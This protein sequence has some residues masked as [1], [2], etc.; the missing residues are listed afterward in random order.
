MLTHNLC[1]SLLVKPF[2]PC[3]VH[4]SIHSAVAESCPR[5]PYQH[6][7]P[8]MHCSASD[9]LPCRALGLRRSLGPVAG[10]RQ[11]CPSAVDCSPTVEGYSDHNPPARWR[12]GMPPRTCHQELVATAAGS[13]VDLVVRTVIVAVFASASGS[14]G[15]AFVPRLLDQGF[16]VVSAE[17]R[18]GREILCHLVVSFN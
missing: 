15:S 11:C 12:N 4:C 5:T 1:Q 3:P 8:Q 7:S 10:I 16:V 18:K 17:P 9:C 6:R 14:A 13:E 2:C